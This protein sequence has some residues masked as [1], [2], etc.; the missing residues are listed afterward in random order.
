ML[1]TY[2]QK[3]I[4]LV[5]LDPTIGHEQKGIRPAVIISA[6]GF[7]NSGMCLMCPL[8]QKIKDFFGDVILK[9]NKNNGLEKNSE[10][11]IGQIRSVDQKRIIRTIGKIS[12]KELQNILLGINMLCGN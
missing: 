8:T 7:H 1:K 9:P 12:Q 6:Q 2:E 4:V 3:D 5:S 10:I 11:L